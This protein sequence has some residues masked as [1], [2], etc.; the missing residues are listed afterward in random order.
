MLAK[1]HNCT[2]LRTIVCMSCTIALVLGRRRF[3]RSGIADPEQAAKSCGGNLDTNKAQGVVCP[4][5]SRA[6]TVQ[7]VGGGGLSK[8]STHKTPTPDWK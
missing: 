1:K 8:V 7:P 2:P 5:P 3:A 6:G 4:C